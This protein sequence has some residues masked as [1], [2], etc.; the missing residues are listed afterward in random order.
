[1]K[2]AEAKKREEDED[3]TQVR[4][5]LDEDVGEES[6]GNETERPRR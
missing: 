5:C 4:R 2:A 1:M 6:D 3:E